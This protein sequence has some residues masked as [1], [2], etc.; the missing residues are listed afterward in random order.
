MRLLT[1]INVDGP[2][3]F[4]RAVP[5][6][7]VALALVCGR[8]DP[9]AGGDGSC[10]C[11]RAFMGLAS[12]R[13]TTA[14]AVSEVDAT[15]ADLTAMVDGWLASAGWDHPP[16]LVTDFVDEMVDLGAYFDLGAVLRRIRE[17][18]EVAE[19]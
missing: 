18:D 8:D 14:A 1:A 13:P 2:G 5:G 7:L 15:R 10:G 12:N 17:T 19:R 11:G 9:Q 6:E 16:E 4:C 3:E